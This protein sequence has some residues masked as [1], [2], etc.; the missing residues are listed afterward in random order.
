M[1]G[2]MVASSKEKWPSKETEQLERR[3]G[4][5]GAVGAE[6]GAG[7]PGTLEAEPGGRAGGQAGERA[8]AEPARCQRGAGAAS[9][10]VR[11]E[12]LGESCRLLSVSVRGG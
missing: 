1:W 3:Q 2:G 5:R 12:A 11:R 9:G 6:C 8:R 4:G 10:R 7:T